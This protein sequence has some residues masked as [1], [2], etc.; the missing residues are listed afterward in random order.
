MA[1]IC[2]ASAALIARMRQAKKDPADACRRTARKAAWKSPFAA[3]GLTMAGARTKVRARAKKADVRRSA[4]RPGA[5]TKPGTVKAR[6]QHKFV[7]S[8]LDPADFKSDGLRTYAHYRDLGVKDAT[9]GMALAHVIRFVGKCDPKVVS[10]RHT[11]ECE[12][13]MIYVL[14]GTITTE[15][16][17]HG[18][19]VMSAGDSWLQ[20]QSIVHKVLDYTDGCEV[21]EIVLPADF[22]TVELEK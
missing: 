6:R 13:Q 22:K 17:G 1:F 16:E 19:H 2:A 5:R 18:C 8:H 3:G 10:K 20:P 7:A 14:K 9:R 11:H 4:A 12:F 15:I 21:L